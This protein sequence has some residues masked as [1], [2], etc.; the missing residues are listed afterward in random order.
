MA[1]C[2]R[3]A[4]ESSVSIG[5]LPRKLVTK[6]TPLCPYYAAGCCDKD[7]CVYVHGDVCDGCGLAQLHP[8]NQGQRRQHRLECEEDI[9]LELDITAAIAASA[10]KECGICLESVILKTTDTEEEDD[11]LAR[12]FGIL[13]N[14]SHCFC[15]SCI[16]KWRETRR[17]C[18]MCRTES[19]FIINS[20][21]YFDSRQEKNLI[22]ELKR[23]QETDPNNDVDEDLIR[24][25][26][27]FP[28]GGD[29]TSDSEYSD[30]TEIESESETDE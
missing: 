12:R 5:G 29:D 20:R 4:E 28:H 22:E 25:L 23:S 17:T 1:S 24:D 7:D 15:L 26:E 10:D 21:H 6:D 11:K 2:A 30:A 14:C 3:K 13:E 27:N 16:E 8:L 18:P 19:H 9:D